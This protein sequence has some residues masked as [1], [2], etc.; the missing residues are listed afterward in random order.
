MA[1]SEQSSQES[2]GRAHTARRLESV[3]PT[4]NVRHVDQ[5]EP[6]ELEALLALVGTDASIPVEASPLE[7]GDVI[8]FTDY[9]G[10]ER[11]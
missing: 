2:V 1:L 11:V 10:V 6:D 4:R 5:L 3:D 7:P 8:V 9:Y